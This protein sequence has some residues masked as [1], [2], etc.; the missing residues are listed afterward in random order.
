LLHLPTSYLADFHL[1]LPGD[2]IHSFVCLI[3]DIIRAAE[4]SVSIC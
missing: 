1:N 4:L 2:G 3:P